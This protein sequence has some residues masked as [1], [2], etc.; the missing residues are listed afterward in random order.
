M[1]ATISHKSLIVYTLSILLFG[2]FYIH[3]KQLYLASGFLFLLFFS[4]WLLYKP[5][6]VLYLYLSSFLPLLYTFGYLGIDNL[7]FLIISVI[8]SVSL[9]LS[10]YKYKKPPHISKNNFLCIALIF[11]IISFGLLNDSLG[12]SFLISIR[13]IVYTILPLIITSF[14]IK[15]DQLIQLIDKAIIFNSIITISIIL[16]YIF[17]SYAIFKWKIEST[18]GLSFFCLISISLIV[19]RKAR[20]FYHRLVLVLSIGLIVILF[21]RA[22]ILSVGLMIIWMIISRGSLN[23]KLKTLIIIGI[24]SLLAVPLIIPDARL[25]K[26]RQTEVLTKNIKNL[27]DLKNKEE[28]GSIGDRLYLWDFSIKYTLKNSPWVGNGFGEFKNVSIFEYP[29]N[30]VIDIFF[31]TGIL[32]TF[33]F[34]LFVVIV[35][36]L[37]S[38]NKIFRKSYE[39]SA[40]IGILG[41]FLTV[42]LFSGG[43]NKS[44]FY[45]FIYLIGFSLHFKKLHVN[46]L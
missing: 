35:I 24:A 36:Y 29:H 39:Y 19:L 20:S 41:S 10:I 4:I 14:I 23:N 31:C 22:F 25:E 3:Q 40:L 7:N 42:L 43:F 34:F 12:E 17:N 28:L 46:Y 2:V 16:L 32:G 15:K 13:F 26:I 5:E 38:E 6:I 45:L 18:I 9:L 33:V 1:K 8:A 44:S 11:G 30:L 21:Q 37:L 27:D